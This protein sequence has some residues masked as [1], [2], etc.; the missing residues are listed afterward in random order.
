MSPALAFEIR[1]ARA[2]DVAA[3]AT[4]HV[5]TFKETHGRHKAPGFA[6]RESQWRAAFE[7]KSDS[8]CYV[9]EDRDGRLIGFAKGERHHGGVPAFEGELDKIYV[10]RAWHRRG[11]G[12]ALA[13]AVAKRFLAEGV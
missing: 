11:V 7:Q 3:L 12:R 9:A 2:D 10:L 8:F 5:E 6:L 4:L 1:E 13:Q